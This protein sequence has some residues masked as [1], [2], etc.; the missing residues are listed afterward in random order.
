MPTVTGVGRVDDDVLAVG[1]ESR[2]RIAAPFAFI[3][4]RQIKMAE[5][6]RFAGRYVIKIDILLSL[7][8]RIGIVEDPFIAGKVGAMAVSCHYAF[9]DDFDLSCSVLVEIKCVTVRRVPC[10]G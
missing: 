1:A 3:L 10:P 6:H 4:R 8:V 9:A 2:V 5:R 7:A